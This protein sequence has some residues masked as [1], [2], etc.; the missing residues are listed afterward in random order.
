MK[1]FLTGLGMGV[2]LA[3]LFAPMTGKKMRRQISDR[4]SDLAEAGRQRYGDMAE[5]ARERYQ[6]VRDNASRAMGS[7]REMG[8]Q[9]TG[10]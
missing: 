5:T 3:L 4:A 7:V 1:A 6:E 8:N 10:S 2:G 9:I